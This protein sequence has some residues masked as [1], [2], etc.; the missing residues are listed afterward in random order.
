GEHQDRAGSV[1]VQ[2]LLKAAGGMLDAVVDDRRQQAYLD[3]ALAAGAGIAEEDLQNNLL[4]RTWS[5]AGH[6]DYSGRMAAL[7][8]ETRLA[9][10]LSTDREM[11]PEEYAAKLS[12]RRRSI[13][14]IIEIG[15]AHV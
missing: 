1:L 8:Y 12:E 5:I 6:S 7:E 10:E 4:T 2:H 3:G 11:P 13:L 9:S 14:P 15:R